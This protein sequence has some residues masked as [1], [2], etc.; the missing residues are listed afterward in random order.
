MRRDRKREREIWG[1]MRKD[2][3]RE[4]GRYGVV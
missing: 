3:K 2:R 1:G 4:R